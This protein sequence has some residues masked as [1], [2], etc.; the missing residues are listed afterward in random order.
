MMTNDKWKIENEKWKGQ[1]GPSGIWRL[2]GVK[3]TAKVRRDDRSIGANE[4]KAPLHD[5]V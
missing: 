4:P 3:L 1:T 5:H 2:S